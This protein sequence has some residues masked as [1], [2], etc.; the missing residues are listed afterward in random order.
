MNREQFKIWNAEAQKAK[1]EWRLDI[2][3]SRLEDLIAFKE[4]EPGLGYFLMVNKG[5]VHVGEYKGAI[6]HIGEAQF[7]IS[8][9]WNLK[10]S[11]NFE[12][13][14]HSAI[15]TVAGDKIHDTIYGSFPAVPE[16]A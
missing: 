5:I 13:L 14:L 6:P 4:V 12:N 2:I 8:G 15:R 1:G 10:K 3:H 16:L 7:H 11:P 9:S